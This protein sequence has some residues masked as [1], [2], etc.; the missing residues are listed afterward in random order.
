[1]Q[2]IQNRVI[3]PVFGLAGSE[4]HFEAP[5]QTSDIFGDGA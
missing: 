1:M 4:D 2:I 5:M 3:A